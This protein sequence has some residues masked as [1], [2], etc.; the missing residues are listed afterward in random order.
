ML[1]NFFNKNFINFSEYSKNQNILIKKISF[2]FII[3]FSMLPIKLIMVYNISWQID[4]QEAATFSM[5]NVV[6]VSFKILLFFFIFF[7]RLNFILKLKNRVGFKKLIENFL[8]FAKNPGWWFPLANPQSGEFTDI[9]SGTTHHATSLHIRQMINNIG[10]PPI[11]R[12][13]SEGPFLRIVESPLDRLAYRMNQ[14]RAILLQHVNRAA[15]NPAD[16]DNAVFQNSSGSANNMMA[17]SPCSPD[18]SDIF[19]IE[20]FKIFV[21][22]FIGAFVVLFLFVSLMM[23]NIKLTNLTKDIMKYFPISNFIGLFMFIALSSSIFK[24]FP[25]N[26]YIQ[27]FLTN[28]YANWLDKTDFFFYIQLIG[29]TVHTHYI[30]LFLIS[31]FIL[32]ITKKVL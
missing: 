19:E 10:N 31:G 2:L 30:L 27:S 4:F 28:V 18:G 5:L 25:N 13:P 21:I 12:P 17:T 15:G 14:D 29:Q 16:L 1:I 24:M 32:L 20:L 22:F 7:T 26:S 11:L 9:C 6:V 3:A 23:L 8:E